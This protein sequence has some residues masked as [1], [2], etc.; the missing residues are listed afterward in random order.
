MC[1]VPP[2]SPGGK[3]NLSFGP[4]PPPPGKKILDPRMQRNNIYLDFIYICKKKIV[5][6]DDIE[7]NSLAFI[8]KES[9]AIMYKKSFIDGACNNTRRIIKLVVTSAAV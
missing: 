5:K 2:P 7:L 3:H 6:L 9:V 8:G 1:L 4:P